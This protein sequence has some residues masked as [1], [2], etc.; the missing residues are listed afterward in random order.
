MAEEAHEETLRLL[1]AM[2]PIASLEIALL[3]RVVY[4]GHESSEE[5]GA[6]EDGGR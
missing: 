6:S 4:S 3:H 2:Q 5:D 1:D